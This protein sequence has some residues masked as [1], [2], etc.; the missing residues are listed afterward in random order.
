M[1]GRVGLFETPADDEF[2]HGAHMGQAGPCRNAPDSPRRGLA[3]RGPQKGARRHCLRQ[4]QARAR[5]VAPAAR[6]VAPCKSPDERPEHA[7][8]KGAWLS[9]VQTMHSLGPQQQAGKDAAMALRLARNGSANVSPAPKPPIALPRGRT[10]GI[11]APRRS[12]AGNCAPS[13]TRTRQCC[14]RPSSSSHRRCPR[15]QNRI[16]RPFFALPSR[17]F[18][19]FLPPAWSG[20]L[21]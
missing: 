5:T 2:G 6:P 14:S 20:P 21:A 1:P 19:R 17:G 3:F 12:W 11:A 15:R 8:F 7:G 4:M 16:P 10:R 9:Q 13:L 18:S